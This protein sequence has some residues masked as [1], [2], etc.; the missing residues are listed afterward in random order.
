M[1]VNFTRSATKRLCKQYGTCLRTL[2]SP[3]NNEFENR[4][5]Q[6]CDAMRDFF[7]SSNGTGQAFAD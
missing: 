5:M 4:F 3:L 1:I 6:T 2:A 7:Q